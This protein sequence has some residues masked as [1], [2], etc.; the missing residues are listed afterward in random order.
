MPPLRIPS[1]P[2]PQKELNPLPGPRINHIPNNGIGVLANGLFDVG[3]AFKQVSDAADA[4]EAGRII[5]ETQADLQQVVKQAAIDYQDPEEFERVAKERLEETRRL[6]LESA[7]N[8]KVR[9]NVM[10]HIGDDMILRNTDIQVSKFSKMR[11]GALGNWMRL[12]EQS[13]A[14]YELQDDPMERQ[15]IVVNAGVTLKNL[16]DANLMDPDDK[17][18]ELKNMSE[19]FAELDIR[20]D[21]ARDPE[22]TLAKLNR[23]SNPNTTS[24]PSTDKEFLDKAQL[25]SQYAQDKGTSL[26]GRRAQETREAVTGY[27][28]I[29]PEK[30]MQI[31][32]RLATEYRLAQADIARKTRERQESNFSDML[33]RSRK[34]GAL[35]QQEIDS[36]ASINPN[37]TRD[38]DA[39][40]SVH[41]TEQLRATNASAGVRYSNPQ[42][43]GDMRYRAHFGQLNANEVRSQQMNGQL[44][45]GDAESLYTDID[46]R[47]ARDR[48]A[49]RE[50]QADDISKHPQYQQA[51]GYITGS[52][53]NTDRLDLDH[54]MR[55]IV[56]QALVDF[57]SA[58]RKTDKEGNP[59]YKPEDFQ[60]I[61]E[62]VT[63]GA[64][65]KMDYQGNYE[66]SKLYPGIKTPEDVAEAVRQKRISP[67]QAKEQM[68]Y[69]MNLGATTNLGAGTAAPNQQNIPPSNQAKTRDEMAKERARAAG[70]K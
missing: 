24:G 23:V 58:V 9:E 56:Q 46:S 18:R 43:L 50:K 35:T 16:A 13:V 51:R 62:T 15:R 52:L 48:A 55:A 1:Y 28:R 12:R 11:Q 41:L 57:D 49:A 19:R 22:G 8:A 42:V 38:I 68:R 29:S 67:A 3:T 64:L 65:I 31:A 27:G 36:A 60:K 7:S 69:L 17:E 61:A 21:F 37:G 40:Q 34:P 53:P 39:Q 47:A 44:T 5:R 30:R 66:R 26:M 32:D 63:Q 4:A 54:G 14:D 6:R 33:I 10:N 20:R 25:E 2:T 70:A 59:V 45:I